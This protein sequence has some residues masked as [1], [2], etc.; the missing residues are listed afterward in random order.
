MVDFLF[1]TYM[2][3]MHRNNSEKPTFVVIFQKK[4]FY[5]ISF[6]YQ[7]DDIIMSLVIDNNSMFPVVL[8]NH[9]QCDSQRSI[10]HSISNHCVLCLQDIVCVCLTLLGTNRFIFNYRGSVSH[11][12]A[13]KHVCMYF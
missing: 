7:Y 1:Y 12:S 11:H 2:R 10:Q 3:C 6:I 9:E 5:S 4:C 13:D 8:T